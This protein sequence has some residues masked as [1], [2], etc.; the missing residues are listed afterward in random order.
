MK[1]ITSYTLIFIALSCFFIS[2]SS[3]KKED[4][5]KDRNKRT[6]LVYMVGKTRDAVS[7]LL[8]KDFQ[9]LKEGYE[10]LPNNKEFDLLV[11]ISNDG[12][13]Q[14]RKSVV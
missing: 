4:L 2:C 10:L 1:P 7:G 12:R 3:D 9:E 5:P 6:V 13:F 11:F 14:D 8:E